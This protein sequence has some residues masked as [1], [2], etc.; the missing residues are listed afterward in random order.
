MTDPAGM[1]RRTQGADDGVS[2]PLKQ[3]NERRE[4]GFD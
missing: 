4:Q 3:A 1:I 2:S